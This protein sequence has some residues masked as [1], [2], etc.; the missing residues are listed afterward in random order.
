MKY[1]TS[2]K[3]FRLI[4]LEFTAILLVTSITGCSVGPDFHT[5][6]SPDAK[7]Y[8]QNPLPNKTAHTTGI[9]GASQYFRLNQNIPA[10]WWT[11]FRSK[12]LNTLIARG[13]AN[14]PTLESAKAA[15]KQAQE[16]L[17]AEVGTGLFPSVSAQ[18]AATRQNYPNASSG[19]E[20]GDLF[21]LYNSSVNVSYNLD[22]FGGLRR[23]L[24][25][26]QAQVDY[27]KFQ[28]EA[29]YLTL[30]A[31]IAT[32]AITA[33]SLRA[34]IAD[35]QALIRSQ[36]NTFGITQ[37]QLH[38]GGASEADVL[39]QQTQLAQTRAT[40]PPLQKS[41]AQY[42]NSLAVLVGA[43][44]SE[45]GLPKLT[46]NELTLPL[47]LP[48]SVPSRLT[49]QRPDIRAAEALLHQASAQVGVAKANRFP[50]FP[51]TA[52]YG[53][54]STQKAGFFGPNNV[55]WNFGGQLNQ[56]IFDAGSLKAKQKVAVAA[57]EQSAAQYRQTVLEAFQNVA[58][59]LHAIQ[60][61]ADALK[62]Q[63]TAEQSAQRTFSL[64]RQQYALGAVSY[65]ALLD[66]ERQYQ[67]ASISRIQAQAARYVDTAA[68]FQALGGGWW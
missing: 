33:A 40:L 56:S 16:N 36:E 50:Q 21:N 53:Y 52:S 32:T 51:L 54:S 6:V 49:R 25:G 26:L 2:W 14:S 22:V 38:L 29:A 68:L 66:A 37:R 62:A 61:D 13:I 24:E 27:Q 12:N 59:A 60:T 43:L 41:L 30:S 46:L 4:Q 42:E 7:S 67:Q 35:T 47:Q 5:P 9:A 15:I 28:L 63:T 1:K 31:N 17:N 10:Q 39:L 23:T 20:G 57:Y 45:V 8:T 64:I 18:L 3:N 11:L 19:G 55:F 48:I 65:L 44:P 34:Q 58:D